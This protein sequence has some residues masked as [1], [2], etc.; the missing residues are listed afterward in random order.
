MVSTPEAALACAEAAAP[1]LSAGKGYVDVSTVDS[2]G[3]PYT[4]NPV[5]GTHSLKPP[6]FNP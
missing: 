6:G 4:L 5:G 3:P 2:V 1:G